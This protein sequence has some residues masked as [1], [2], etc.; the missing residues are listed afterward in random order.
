MTELSGLVTAN[1]T[2]DLLKS[3]LAGCLWVAGPSVS[4]MWKGFQNHSRSSKIFLW[5]GSGSCYGSLNTAFE[6]V[7][8]G[9]FAITETEC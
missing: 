8:V 5:S 7:P 6:P 3:T 9:P 1:S 2:Q 4:L